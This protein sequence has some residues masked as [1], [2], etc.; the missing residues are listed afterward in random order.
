M[1]LTHGS[2][3]L[4]EKVYEREEFG[5]P[6]PYGISSAWTRPGNNSLSDVWVL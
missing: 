2:S 3:N 5:G 6:P 4:V 1:V